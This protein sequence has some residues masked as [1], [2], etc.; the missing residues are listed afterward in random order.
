MEDLLLP[1]WTI[2]F[3]LIAT[4]Q[5]QVD[6]CLKQVPVWKLMKEIIG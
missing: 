4:K 1:N 6:T 2:S 5:K 3:C